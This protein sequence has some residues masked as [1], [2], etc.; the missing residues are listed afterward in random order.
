[1]SHL[2]GR[3]RRDQQRAMPVRERAHRGIVASNGWTT[4]SAAKPS[5]M[6]RSDDAEP[7]AGN[8]A[9]LRTTA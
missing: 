3:S 2:A 4:A 8:R 5:P 7:M 6:W 1:M 9:H